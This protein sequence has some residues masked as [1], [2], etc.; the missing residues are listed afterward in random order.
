MERGSFLLSFPKRDHPFGEDGKKPRK[1][2][3]HDRLCS[4]SHNVRL[5]D[6][7]NDGRSF[8]QFLQVV[9]VRVVEIFSRPLASQSYN[10]LPVDCVFTHFLGRFTF[11]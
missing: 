3:F 10:A 6:L 11:R 2:R 4:D 7:K 1:Y 8:M 5:G 9:D